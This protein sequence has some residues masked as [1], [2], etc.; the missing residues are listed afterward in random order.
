MLKQLLTFVCIL[1]GIKLLISIKYSRVI[2]KLESFTNEDLGGNILTKGIQNWSGPNEYI[3]NIG[4]TESA[5]NDETTEINKVMSFS[6]KPR[7]DSKKVGF[8]YDYSDSA[9]M[10]PGESYSLTVYAK[11]DSLEGLQVQPY[12]ADNEESK[13]TVSRVWM[14]S[15]VVKGGD[16]WKKLIWTFKNHINS[17]AESLSFKFVGSSDQGIRH[18]IFK[19]ELRKVLKVS[20]ANDKSD[21]EMD[22]LKGAHAQEIKKMEKKSYMQLL[23][24]YWY[25]VAILV[26]LGIVLWVV[27]SQKAEVGEEIIPIVTETETPQMEPTL[28]SSIVK[29]ESGIDDSSLNVSKIEGELATDNIDNIVKPPPPS[30]EMPEIMEQPEFPQVDLAQDVSALVDNVPEAVPD[31]AQSKFDLPTKVGSPLA[32]LGPNPILKDQQ[33]LLVGNNAAQ[34]SKLNF[35]IAP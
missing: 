23:K 21:A 13:D 22:A 28:E 27:F 5:P 25:I 26:L 24:E 12:T 14:N 18:T 7:L 33:S 31:V 16:G 1:I 8:L 2:A 15:Q 6:I 17:K 30:V 3:T 10:I 35:P 4:Y 29:S 20:I 9:K 32:N 19:P 34:R 11:T